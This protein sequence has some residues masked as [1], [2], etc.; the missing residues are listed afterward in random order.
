VR[1]RPRVYACT[2]LANS[3]SLLLP[4]SNLT[5][6]LAMSAGGLTFLG[7]AALM[8]LPWLAVIGVE[9]AI[10]RRFF[11]DD[12]KT[13]PHRPPAQDVRAPRFALAVLG[14]TLVGFA[15]A[16]TIGVNPAW[17][18]LAGALALA[19]RQKSSVRTLV[20]EANPGFCLF[21]LARGWSCSG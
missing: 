8:A 20:R 12:L 21:V 19:V 10:L 7:F 15:V 6:L 14:V 4:V 13:P 3:A 1:P 2:H 9:Y 17:V 11:A 5:N 16:S 18:A